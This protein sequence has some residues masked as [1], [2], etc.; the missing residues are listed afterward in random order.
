MALLMAGVMAFSVAGCGGAEG[1][2]TESKGDQASKGTPKI[3]V[4]SFDVAGAL[5]EASTAYLDYLSKELGFEYEY[6]SAG[7]SSQEQ[8]STA[9]TYLAQGYRGIILNNDMG[10]A[11]AILDLCED[12]DA[13]LGGYWCDFANSIYSTGAPNMA[14]LENDRFVGSVNDGTGVYTDIAQEMFNAIVIRDGHTKIGIATMP[15]AWYPMQTIEGVPT[16]LGLIEEYNAGDKAATN[17]EPVEVAQIGTDDEGNPVYF[18]QVDGESMSFSSS[19]FTNN[20]MTA[21]A[22]FASSSFTYGALVES[23]ADVTLYATGWE[24]SFESDF[25]D[26]KRINMIITSPVETLAFPV[27]MILDR[28]NGNS[29]PDTLTGE[30]AFGKIVPADRIFNVGDEGLANFKKSLHYT[31]DASTAYFTADDVKNMMVTYNS[32]ATFADSAALLNSGNMTMD[33]LEKR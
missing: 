32:S 30:A 9:E 10:G 8:I 19:F 26:G 13:Y 21:C 6:V 24:N 17:G 18:E 14:V 23:K 33:A 12:Y 1:G 7:F 2:S 25:G 29:Y 16:L 3:V 4:M 5:Y 20:D 27:A 11:E 28:I 15:S 22:S 31:A